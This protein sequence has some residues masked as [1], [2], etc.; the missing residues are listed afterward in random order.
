MKK[1]IVANWKMQ[2]STSDS[3]FLLKQIANFSKPNN[4]LIVCPNF[5][6]VL[7]AAKILENTDT[8]LGAQNCSLKER[9]ALTGEVSPHDLRLAG[10][11]YVIIG[12]SERRRLFKED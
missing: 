9:G 7:Q 1:L 10:C 3:L 6:V 12:H 8:K 2:V 5:L 4:D 11:S